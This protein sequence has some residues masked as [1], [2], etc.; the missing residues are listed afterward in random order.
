[1]TI[2]AV[3]IYKNNLYRYLVK[4]G[5][6]MTFGTGKKDTVQVPG[7][8]AHQIKVT[9]KNNRVILDAKAVYNVSSDKVMMSEFVPLKRPDTYMYF[10][11]TPNT[12]AKTF[13]LPYNG[14][15][16]VGK[17]LLNNDI[18]IRFPF[19]SDRHFDIWC[20]NGNARIED[21]GSTNGTFLNGRKI[22]K[23]ALK[24]NDVISLLSVNIVVSKGEL[25]FEGVGKDLVIKNEPQPQKG[26]VQKEDPLQLLYH[27]SPRI[28]EAL[29]EKPIVLSSPPSKG[30]KYT[31]SHGTAAVLASSG[32]MAAASMLM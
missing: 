1:M 7:F 11:V 29:P 25:I 5:E 14:H 13:K 2:T 3:L 4:D 24:N 21:V 27:K 6:D 8:N 15:V 23:G 18:V 17:K 9:Y 30:S 16:K 28:Q 22:E 32:S 26:E 12:A 19:I 31:R 20:E 10:T